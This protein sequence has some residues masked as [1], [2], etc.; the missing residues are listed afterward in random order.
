MRAAATLLFFLLAAGASAAAEDL[1]RAQALFAA[2][3]IGAQGRACA[4]CHGL[5]GR[6]GGE[7][8]VRAPPVRWSDLVARAGYDPAALGRA[9]AEGTAPGGRRLSRLMPRYRDAAATA[10]ALAGLLA[11][12][13]RPERWGVLPD[14]VRV[15]VPLPPG[16][17]PER[18]RAVSIL[19]ALAAELGAG[20]YGRRLEIVP[21]VR[22]ARVGDWPAALLQARVLAVVAGRGIAPD[23]A[24]AQALAAAG[25]VNLFPV[26]QLVGG[27]D[28]QRVRGHF[29][30]RESVGG[31]LAEAIGS[32]GARRV[33]LVSSPETDPV[34]DA[35]VRRI[36]GAREPAPRLIEVAPDWSA[37]AATVARESAEAVLLLVAP[38]PSPA[39]PRLPA[40]LYAPL[41]AL[42]PLAPVLLEAGNR[43]VLADPRPDQDEPADPVLS[44]LGR[45]APD[46]VDRAVAAAGRVLILALRRAGRDLT[47][48]VLLATLGRMPPVKPPGW[49]ELDFAGN[50]LAGT[51]EVQLL[52]LGP[53]EAGPAGRG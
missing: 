17:D 42:G 10:P 3:P 52:T 24:A 30:T 18:D 27:A 43:L 7:G 2:G 23:S 1:V 34:V 8:R 36:L 33:A 29:A 22:P 51:S 20:L 4:A 19:R 31:R 21:L 40:T 5:D 50:P 28:P 25:L 6:G 26:A 13:D 46:D 48:G 14:R 47:P 11:D 32:S 16:G 39:P 41:D 49:P 37:L 12:L 53:A 45:E 15:G 9:L 38:P 35:A 44:R